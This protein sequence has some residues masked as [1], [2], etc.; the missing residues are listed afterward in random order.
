MSAFEPDDRLIGALEQARPVPS[1]SFR[2]QLRSVLTELL[3]SL[4]P[5]LTPEMRRR[6]LTL[7]AAGS[8]LLAIAA[9][10]LAGIGPFAA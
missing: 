3:A 10:G 2:D 7:A 5:P 1:P 4:P 6:M 8:L 9:A